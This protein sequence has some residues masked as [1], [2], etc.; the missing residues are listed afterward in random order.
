MVQHKR[1]ILVSGMGTTPA[2]LTNTV[3]GLAHQQHPIVPDEIVVFI[4][5][6]C[7]ELL[8]QNLFDDGVWNAMLSNLKRERIMVEGKLV[9]G[10]TSIRVIPDVAGNEINDLRTGDDNLRAA[11]FMLSQLRQYTEDSGTELHVSI[12]GGRK[13]M[14]ALL[15]S[16]MTLLGREC[17]KVYHVLLPQ[18]LEQG[19]TPEFFYPEPGKMFIS[20]GTDRRLKAEQIKTE[21]FEVPFVRM[22]GW[23]QEKFKAIPPNYRTLVYRIQ[24]VAPRAVAYPEISIDVQ[25]GS[26][27]VNGESVTMSRTCFALLVVIASG[28]LVRDLHD[29]LKKLHASKSMVRCDWLDAFREGSRFN[30]HSERDDLFKT[31]SDLRKRLSAGGLACVESLVPKRDSPI[32]FPLSRIKW[33]GKECLADICGYPILAGE[34]SIVIPYAASKEK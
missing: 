31:M 6:S 28:C 7:K 32:T 25:S 13:T 18:E 4:T 11:D 24:T 34:Q 20:R 14:S 15:F 12:A 10:E 16:C 27:D 26:V 5:K 3:W 33:R 1:V 21:L 8:V 23:Y 30:D 19:A 9:F 17:D 2:V 29:Q 22:R